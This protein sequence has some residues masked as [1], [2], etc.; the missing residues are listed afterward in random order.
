MSILVEL[1]FVG[2]I[3]VV[4]LNAPD[5]RNAVS[6][7]MREILL[8]HLTQC[9]ASG[10]VGAIVLTGAA[11]NFSSGGD[12]KAADARAAQPD[13]ERTRRNVMLFHDIVRLIAYGPKPVLAAVEGCAYGAGFSLAAICDYIVASDTARFCASFGKIGL[14]ADAGLMW[15]L[16]QRVGLSRSRHLLL[17][18]QVVE[19]K[20]AV[21]I[22]LADAPAVAGQAVEVALAQAERFSLLAPLATAAMKSVLG[23]GPALLENV[24]SAEAELQPELSKSSD[25]AEGRAAFIAR[26]A[27]VFRGC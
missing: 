26:R 15:S 12:V 22:G 16:P 18:A 5:R 7:E 6:P 23:K 21:A 17:T 2:R 19:A 25:Y 14:V 4:T 13:P 11:G 10:E 20:E 27:P 9:M 8:G 24:L 1:R 3:A